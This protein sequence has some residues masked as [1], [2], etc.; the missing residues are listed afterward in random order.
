VGD[1]STRSSLAVPTMRREN[2]S[3]WRPRPSSPGSPS[4]WRSCQWC[5]S[6]G[7][8]DSTSELGRGHALTFSA[9]DGV[10]KKRRRRQD[11]PRP[12][13]R[14]LANFSSGSGWW[15]HASV[16]TSLRDMQLSRLRVSIAHYAPPASSCP[17]PLRP[18]SLRRRFLGIAKQPY[19]ALQEQL[20]AAAAVSCKGHQTG[21]PPGFRA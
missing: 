14:R 20:R 1:R 16:V 7:R 19:R 18:H 6:L 17:L 15:K 13:H 12:R 8:I 21:P 4:V 5:E 11:A 3:G 2:S 10:D 9:H